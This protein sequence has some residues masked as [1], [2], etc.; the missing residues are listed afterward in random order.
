MMK[1]AKRIHRGKEGKEIVFNDYGDDEKILGYF[2]TQETM[3]MRR[4][5]V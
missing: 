3:N 1:K 4:R 5:T 2:I